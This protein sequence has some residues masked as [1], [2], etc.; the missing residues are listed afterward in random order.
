MMG[1]PDHVR[2]KIRE[3]GSG[4]G[5]DLNANTKALY[6][7]LLANGDGVAHELDIGYGDHQ[8]QKLDVYHIADGRGGKTIVVYIPGGGFTGGDKRQD[9]NFF[10]NVGRFFARQGMVG[11]TAN[12]R[13]SPEFAWPCAGQ[14]VQSAVRWIKTN[15]ARFGADP[16][17]IVIVGHSAG[18]SHVASYLFDPDL[19]GGDEVMA[20]V[21]ASG[22]YVLRRE[23][24]RPN[25][26]QYFGDED[27]NFHHRSALSHVAAS[28]VPV[29]LAVA[30]HDPVYLITPTFEMA[31]ALA[32]R[33]G[34]AP[35]IV[36]LAGHNH[37]STMCTF[38]TS[39]DCFS[40]PLVDFVN[41]R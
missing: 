6:A 38:G 3:W 28:K 10:S 17:R 2:K 25:V 39:D 16:D 12:Y 40:G 14:D 23:E 30:E 37:F 29:F 31:R 22:L 7:P 34:S 8:R 18:A 21:L 19:R 41:T 35:H 11:V 24:M 36:R 4:A 9:E 1:M 27:A 32:L 13:L 20:G 5:P 33:D 26:A 15:A